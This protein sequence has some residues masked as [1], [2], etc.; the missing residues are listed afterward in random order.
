LSENELKELN[1]SGQVRINPVERGLFGCFQ[2]NLRIV[3]LR[4]KQ[5]DVQPDGG[6]YGDHAI[7]RVRIDH[8]GETLLCSSGNFYRFQ[9]YKNASINPIS[10]ETV[11]DGIDGTLEQSKPSTAAE[12][13][14][15]FLL[16]LQGVQDDERI[17]L[18]S[19]PGAWSDLIIRKEVT[20][21]NGI[22]MS[23][24]SMRLELE[25]D[26]QT[27]STDKVEVRVKDFE[28]LSPSVIVDPVDL[29]GRQDGRGGFRRV[30]PPSQR[31]TFIAVPWY[32]RY[33]FDR[34]VVSFENNLEQEVFATELSVALNRL[35][36]LQPVYVERCADFDCLNSSVQFIRSDVNMD[37]N[38]DLSDAIGILGFLFMG[39]PKTLSC[40]KSADTDDN[41]L[42]NINDAISVL[43]F[44]FL[45][46]KSPAPPFPD[47]GFDMT[48]DE[49][50]CRDF[51]CTDGS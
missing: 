14:I 34:W 51:P 50:S 13:L 18:Y 9:H 41:G 35:V 21:D 4:T 16:G 49:L 19:R 26:Y 28:G 8:S 24:K 20:T 7:L 5:I 38:S 48:S 46:G 44:L 45:G 23:V 29:N 6:V 3:N 47:C 15:R 30:Y 31:V 42:L 1:E 10:W 43:Q 39:Q 11:Y 2:E 25:Y 22:G 37:G 33:Q 40:E 17:M 36:I 27:K 32:G 12:S